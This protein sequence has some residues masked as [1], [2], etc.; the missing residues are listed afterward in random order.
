VR[1]GISNLFLIVTPAQ[2][3]AQ[4][5]LV[6]PL[7]RQSFL[8]TEEFVIP[9]KAGIQRSVNSSRKVIDFSCAAMDSRLR[10]ND[11]IFWA[12]PSRALANQSHWTP[13]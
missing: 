1:E 7:K 9:A 13:A 4:W 12:I 11:R 8:H 6:A 3:G 5:L 2:A 10:G